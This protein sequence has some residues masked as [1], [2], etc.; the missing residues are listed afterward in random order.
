MAGKL[1]KT[2]TNCQ[3]RK[4]QRVY[5]RRWARRRKSGGAEERGSRGVS[6]GLEGRGS[7]RLARVCRWRWA[8]MVVRA[9]AVRAMKGMS[10]LLLLGMRLLR[11]P[12]LRP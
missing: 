9:A 7:Q 2:C 1:P 8:G 12:T 11:R 6:L 10:W 3:R 5:Q 4:R